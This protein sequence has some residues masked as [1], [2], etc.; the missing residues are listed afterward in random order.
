MGQVRHR[1]DT[2]AQA[3]RLDSARIIAGMKQQSTATQKKRVIGRP[4][5]PGVSGNLE[6]RRLLSKRAQQLANSMSADFGGFDKLTGVRRFVGGWL[7][8]RTVFCVRP[9]RWMPNDTT[10]RRNKIAKDR[11]FG[12]N[13]QQATAHIF[14]DRNQ[15]PVIAGPK[16]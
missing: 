15:K 3:S 2:A 10:T 16:S 5:P 6:G 4:F 7:L 13:R 11:A 12:E 9:Q 1:R 8:H 14:G